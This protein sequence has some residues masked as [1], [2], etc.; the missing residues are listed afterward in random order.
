MGGGGGGEWFPFPLTFSKI[1]AC[2][3]VVVYQGEFI[4][5]RKITLSETLARQ[6]IMNLVIVLVC[7]SV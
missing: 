7:G 4:S 6:A 2:L 5:F 3:V 1:L